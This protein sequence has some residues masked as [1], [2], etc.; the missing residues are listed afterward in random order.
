MAQP[1][2]LLL[3]TN[4]PGRAISQSESN[5]HYR[6]KPTGHYAGLTSVDCIDGTNDMPP[7]P[8]PQYLSSESGGKRTGVGYREFGQGFAT[9]TT[10]EHRGDPQQYQ[11]Q[12]SSETSDIRI[13]NE[14]DGWTGNS[15]EESDNGDTLYHLT[16]RSFHGLQVD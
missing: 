11:G 7:E 5:K 4:L 14:R 6:A 12:K 2:E 13:N 8:R 3:C 15:G 9:T 1:L 10:L 16:Q